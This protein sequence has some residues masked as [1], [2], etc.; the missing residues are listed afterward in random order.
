MIQIENLFKTYKVGTVETPALTGV[1]MEVSKGEFVTVVGKSG[2]GKSTLLNVLGLMDTFDEG[3]Y[4]FN[5]D[6]IKSMNA[7]RR[8]NY[9]NATIGFVFQM[10]NLMDSLTVLE[11]VEVPLGYAGVGARERKKKA[12]GLLESVGLGHKL[13][14]F[15]RHLSGGEQQRVSIARALANSPRL[16]LADEPTGNLDEK[17]SAEIMKLLARLHEGGATIIMVTHDPALALY[18][19][20]I[21]RMN[22]G[23]ITQIEL[24]G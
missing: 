15:P 8:A 22:D 6:S 9:R 18:G 19:Q 14:S 3:E 17:N 4:L 5:G 13:K 2:C 20:K 7:I 10:F 11:N 1:S 16:I 23:K 12:A 21:I 24:N